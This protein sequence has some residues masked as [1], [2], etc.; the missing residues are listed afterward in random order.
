MN[1]MRWENAVK[2]LFSRWNCTYLSNISGNSESIFVF[3]HVSR[4]G[5]RIVVEI[6]GSYNGSDLGQYDK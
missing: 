1:R 3:I 6:Q 4:E 5:R 2:D